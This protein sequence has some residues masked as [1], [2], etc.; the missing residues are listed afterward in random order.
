MAVYDGKRMAYAR[1]PRNREK[2][3]FVKGDW[4]MGERGRQDFGPSWIPGC[5]MMKVMDMMD[6]MKVF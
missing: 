4:E 6:M 2:L 5:C 1:R 3:V